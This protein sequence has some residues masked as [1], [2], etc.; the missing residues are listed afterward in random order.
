MAREELI[1]ALTGLGDMEQLI[2][3][4]VYGTAEGRDMVSTPLRHRAA[5]RP[6]GPAGGL[7]RRTAGGTGREL[8]DLTEIGAHIGA[9]ICDEPPFSVREGG[10]IGTATTRRWTAC[11]IMNG[12]RA[13]LA[14]IE[15]KEKERTG[16][17]P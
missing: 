13:S 3:R 6:P 5:A 17:G 14:E 9:A 1:A 8:D 16:I 11:G 10:F 15:A 7:L 2:G 12:G 4:I